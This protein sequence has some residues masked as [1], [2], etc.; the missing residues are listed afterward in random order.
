MT[1]DF[2]LVYYPKK[3]EMDMKKHFAISVL[4]Y[5]IMKGQRPW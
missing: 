2:L 3:L 5:F 4:F 1:S